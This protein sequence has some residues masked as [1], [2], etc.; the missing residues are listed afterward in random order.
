MPG[1][2]RPIRRISFSPFKLRLGLLIDIMYRQF[3]NR[4]QSLSL[5]IRLCTSCVRTKI[6]FSQ[7]ISLTISGLLYVV[8]SHSQRQAEIHMASNLSISGP[9]V[10]LK[11]RALD[12]RDPEADHTTTQRTDILYRPGD[13]IPAVVEVHKHRSFEALSFHG[14]L[15]G[16]SISPTDPHQ[17]VYTNFQQKANI[18]P[19]SQAKQEYG[20]TQPTAQPSTRP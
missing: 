11:I 9:T 17:P 8:H 12:C 20:P 10:S 6:S 1:A 7:L 5:I 15:I 13:I 14:S 3:M 16:R 2:C 19:L 18:V 4:L